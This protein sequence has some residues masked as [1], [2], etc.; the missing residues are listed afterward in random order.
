[1]LSQLVGQKYASTTFTINGR[2]SGKGLA[3]YPAEKEEEAVKLAKI[4]TGATRTFAIKID[5]GGRRKGSWLFFSDNFGSN[6]D[7]AIEIADEARAKYGLS[8]KD[9]ED[10]EL[11]HYFKQ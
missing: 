2:Y 5:C 1:M 9:L 7:I 4:A 8:D 3:I 11:V 6:E 10:M